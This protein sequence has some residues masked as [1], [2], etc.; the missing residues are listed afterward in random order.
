MN[1][2]D[3]RFSGGQ[4]ALPRV[5][6]WYSHAEWPKEVCTG[7]EPNCSHDSHSSQRHAQAVCDALARQGLGGERKIF[8]LRTWTSQEPKS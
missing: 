1:K 5:D 8:P 3:K 7:E 6:V 4:V 2:Y